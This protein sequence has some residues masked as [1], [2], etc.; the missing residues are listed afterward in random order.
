MSYCGGT[1][2]RGSQSRAQTSSVCCIS[3]RT[4]PVRNRWCAVQEA[5]AAGPSSS[6]L[7]CISGQELQFVQKFAN[8]LSLM[9][10]SPRP[11]GWMFQIGCC[12]NPPSASGLAV[13]VLLHLA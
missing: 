11:S 1:T 3:G 13:L 2:S 5:T 7:G 8:G 6:I 10:M 12:G 9:S 4:A